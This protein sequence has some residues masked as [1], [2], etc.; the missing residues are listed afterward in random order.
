MKIIYK[1]NLNAKEYAALLKRPA[2]DNTNVM[3]VIKPVLDEIKTGG[4]KAVLK[5]ASKFDGL[6]SDQIKLGPE[7]ISRGADL[8]ESCVREAIDTAYEN[9]LSFHLKQKPAGYEMETMPG[10]RCSREYR[11][12]ESV[13][14]YIPGGT[15]V[16]PSTMLM[17]GIPA[18]IAG[19]ERTVV[20]SPSKN[21]SVSPALL[22]AAQKCG[23]TEFYRIGGAQAVGMLAYG[24]EETGKVDKIFGPGNQYVTAAKSLVS[25][26]PD[27][28]AIDMP[29]GP[30]EVLIIADRTGIPGFIASDLLSQAEHGK[31]SQ[32]VLVTTD[33]KL[34]GEVVLEIDKQIANLERIEFANAAISNSFILIADDINQA[35]DFS[36]SYAPEHLILSI[37]DYN[38]QKNKIRN[39]GSV[40]LGNYSPES[41]GDYASGT[42]HSLPTYGYAKSFSGVNVESFMKAVTF[43]ELSAEGLKGISGTVV[44]LAET[45]S[46]QA[47]AN[48]VKIRIENGN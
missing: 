4:L 27:G 16:L 40:F 26:D 10:I 43:Q 3:S 29:A 23:I 42:N 20:C 18:K 38:D 1:N 46:L 39:A 24:T 6:N 37:A 8:L 13:G 9:I 19:C 11:A 12:I 35:I 41:A 28:C 17:L 21:G 33:E 14:L 31:D 36:N 7:E 5:Y 34:A 22:Y 44:R 25:I 2:I 32:A 47:H 45:E 48:A 15:A 30:S